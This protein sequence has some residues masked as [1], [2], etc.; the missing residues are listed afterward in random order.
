MRSL[1]S[2][3]LTASSAN[4][5]TLPQVTY[6]FNPHPRLK[7]ST[8]VQKIGARSP[9]FAERNAQRWRALALPRYDT[10]KNGRVSK[11]WP[12]IS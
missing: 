3:A 7:V 10:S 5:Y 2:Q 12:T 1:G 8:P 9:N 11:I 6:D 4:P